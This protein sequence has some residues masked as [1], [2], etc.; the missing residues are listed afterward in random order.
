MANSTSAITAIR[1]AK[2]ES[3]VAATLNRI[4]WEICYRATSSEGLKV[5]AKKNPDALIL[6]D[7]DFGAEQSHFPNRFVVLNPKIELTSEHIQDLLRRVDNSE[8]PQL[9][10]IPL[11]TSSTTVIATL[12]SG[13]GGST[14]AINFAY[15]KSRAGKE[16]LLLDLNQENPFMARYFDIQKINRKILPTEFGFAL[17]EV[18]DPTYFSNVALLANDFD[19]VVIDLGKIP[20]GDWIISGNRIRELC[21]R[22]SMQ[23]ASSLY[24]VARGDLSSLT[25]LHELSIRLAQFSRLPQPRILLIPQSILTGRERR[26][27]MER[28]KEFFGGEA[29]ILPIDV[30]AIER[31]ASERAPLIQVAPKSL[32]AREFS[33]ICSGT[34]TRGR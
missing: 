10:S 21:T 29:R 17:S 31:A 19:E 24:I 5:A 12:D 8:S 4:G 34:S 26:T 11:C 13:V 16:T 3:F 30:R 7:I 15:E 22:W 18:S 25:R 32:L 28:S 1:N 2:E 33:S 27:L 14:C 9:P 6:A 23:S 20:L